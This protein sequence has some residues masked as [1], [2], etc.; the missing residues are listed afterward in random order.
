MSGKKR[1]GV[2]RYLEKAIICLTE[3][4]NDPEITEAADGI[5]S[6]V[7]AFYTAVDFDGG[8]MRRFLRGESEEL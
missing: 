3:N 4:R 7:P 8:I 6:S 2:D 1:A 5:Y